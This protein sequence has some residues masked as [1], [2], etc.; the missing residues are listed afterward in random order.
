MAAE[1]TEP[2]REQRLARLYRML[3]AYETDPAA[4]WAPAYLTTMG[5]EDCRWAIRRL[6]AEN[7]GICHSTE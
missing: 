4:E 7:S 2:T 1:M 5:Q 6:E 3:F